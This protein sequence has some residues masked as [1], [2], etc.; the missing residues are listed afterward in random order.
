M[1]SKEHLMAKKR[2]LAQLEF[3]KMTDK[4]LLLTKILELYPV[5][6][7]YVRAILDSHKIDEDGSIKAT[8]LLEFFKTLYVDDALR[9]DDTININKL[10]SEVEA[11][12]LQIKNN[13]NRIKISDLALLLPQKERLFLKFISFCRK[14]ITSV[15]FF[16]LLLKYATDKSGKI[17]QDA[18]YKMV[19][20]FADEIGAPED[21]CNDCVRYILALFNAD[22]DSTL[23]IFDFPRLFNIE[24]NFLKKLKPHGRFSAVDFDNI[25]KHYD[26]DTN[27]TIDAGGELMALIADVLEYA[28]IRVNGELLFEMVDAALELCEKTNLQKLGTEDLK[29]ILTQLPKQRMG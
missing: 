23:D 24:G 26:R 22:D 19:K 29:I 12:E 17:S 10:R 15:E 6:A 5:K 18:L 21:H 8:E 13:D 20:D 2:S 25:I 14:Q 7:E 9:N 28:D 4:G 3:F 1:K 16:E 27:G 11:F